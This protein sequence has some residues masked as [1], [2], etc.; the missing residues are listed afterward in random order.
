[1]KNSIL[2]LLLVHCFLFGFAQN[3]NY[4]IRGTYL[5]P[6]L[7]EKLQTAQSISDINPGFPASWIGSYVSVE[8]LATNQGETVKATSA[9]DQLS[10]EQLQILK[11]ADIGTDITIDVKYHTQNSSKN[12]DLK[13]INFSYTVIPKVEA[14]YPGGHQLLREYVQE[15][16]IDKISKTAAAQIE[17]ATVSFIV[18]EEGQITDAHISKTSGN[19]EIDQLLLQTMQQMQK[20]KPAENSAGIKVKQEF[21]LSVGNQIGC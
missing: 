7:K 15:N 17:A 1:M 14:K 9:N 19:A 2:T 4:E 12:D 6:I 18:N 10:A 21:T 5:R 8:I 20:W 11:M 16:A 3:I 13:K